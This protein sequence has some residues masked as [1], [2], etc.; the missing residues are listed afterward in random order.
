MKFSVSPLHGVLLLVLG[1]LLGGCAPAG[2]SQLDEEKEPHFLAGKSHVNTMDY[3]AAIGSFE[4]ALAV[5]PKSAAAHFELGWLYDQKAPDPAAAIYH[6]E[7][8]LKLRPAAEKAEWVKQHILA[9]KQELARTVSL[10][11]V[12][13]KQQRDL[14]KLAEDNKRLTEDNRRLNEE[15]ARWRAC[16]AAQPHPQ[17]NPPVRPSATTKESPPTA[18]QPPRPSNQL[19]RTAQPATP[20]PLGA[21][22]Q[23]RPAPPPGPAIPP[24]R[25]AS[26]VGPGG[27]EPGAANPAPPAPAGPVQ[28]S[29]AP[30]AAART[31]LVKPHETLWGIARQSGVKLEALTAANPGINPRRLHPGQMLNLPPP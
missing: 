19:A 22:P 21:S 31:H 30:A 1:L 27:R 20:P 10:G 18:A 24:A 12:T 8:Y 9:C 14:E 26:A 13:E 11:P 2:L 28:P 5:N 29:S 3:P 7:H 4:K 23:L 25:V 17:T 15:V 16:S 6:Y